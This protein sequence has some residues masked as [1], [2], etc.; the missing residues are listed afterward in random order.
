MRSVP[1]KVMDFA[2]YLTSLAND[3]ETTHEMF[4]QQHRHMIVEDEY[5][6]FNVHHGMEHILSDDWQDLDRIF[7]STLQYCNEAENQPRFE[8]CAERLIRHPRLQ[9]EGKCIENTISFVSSYR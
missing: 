1:T 7:I 3:T 5:Y 4:A 2:Q 8:R 6:R 9:Q